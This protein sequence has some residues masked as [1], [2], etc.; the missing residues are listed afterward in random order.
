MSQEA[1]H[2]IKESIFKEAKKANRDPQT[3]SLVAV[4]KGV[5]WDQVLPLYQEGQ[6][7]FG[8]SRIQEAVKKWEQAPQDCRWHMIGSLQS[9]KIRKIVGRFVLIHSVDTPEIAEK[10]STVSAE[11]GVVSQ[12]L[13]EANTSGEASK[14]GLSP[15]LWRE[16]IER[17]AQLPNLS[18]QGMMTMAPL[19]N[20]EK[21][22]R[23]CF[24]NLRLLRDRLEKEA[25][26]KLPILSMGMSH[27]YPLAI[28][29]GATLLRIGTALFKPF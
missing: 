25:G 4:I 26:L 11:L 5:D 22:V 28:A 8:E 19:S 18:I 21:I 1:Y 3:I 24:A 2:R 15:E 29:E 20:D 17:V 7:D 16:Q 9:N 14:H 12:I 6:R 23:T 10:I 27:D 13:L